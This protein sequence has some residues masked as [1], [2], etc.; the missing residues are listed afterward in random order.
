MNYI[1]KL[2]MMLEKKGKRKLAW[3]VLFSI[4]IS[5]VETIGISAIMPFIDIAI[6]FE[7]I[8]TNQYYQWVFDFFGFESEVN[9][10][11][12]FG[13]VLFGFYIF[14][15][16]MNIL[17]SYVTIHFT[18]NLY[19]QITK[20]LYNTYLTMPY[21]GF[22]KINSSYLTKSI[23]TEAALIPRIIRD[24][25]TIISEGFVIVFLYTLMMIAD[26][27]ITI[28]FTFVLS[29]KILFLTQTI[30]KKLKSIGKIREKAQAQ[31]YEIINR[32]F[33]N[34]KQ[35]KL[36]DKDRIEATKNE[37]SSV[38]YKYAEILVTGSFLGTLPKVLIE[39]IG[40]SLVI[41]LLTTLLYLNQ[42]NLAYILPTLSLFVIAF[43]RLL[44]SA[45]RI[46]N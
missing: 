19:A 20:K 9:F 7:K 26:W 31:Y 33:G 23:I 36:H 4:C 14:R 41:L 3:L 37:F 27:K 6:N 25:L 44:P 8:H 10:A 17:Y 30:S 40:F 24:V 2:L 38:V 43:Y 22:T 15:G 16:G 11:I 39:T 28:V 29:I 32:L 21:L 35:Y 34:F 46:V 18:E 13:I 1:Q 45:N 42:S 5:A 12:F